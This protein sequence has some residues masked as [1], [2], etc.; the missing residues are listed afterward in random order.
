MSKDK[1]LVEVKGLKTY[2]HVNGGMFAPK[3]IV[4]AVD[5]VSFKV[6]PGETVG[7]VGESGSGKTTVGRTM[8]RL[9]PAEAGEV[10]FDGK[11]VMKMDRKEL[12]SLRKRM[13]M[14]FQDPA[15]S[16]NPRMTVSTIVSEPLKLH[17]NMTRKERM[18]RV[19][20]LLE[21]SGLSR[22]YVNRYPHEF[23]GGQRQRIGIARALATNPDFIVCDE[24]V[25]AL[26][27]SIQAQILNL[28]KDLQAELGLSYLFVAHNLAVVEHFV[29]RLCV[30]YHGKIVESADR[31]TL[32]ANPQNDYT[33]M[34]L[35]A[36]PSA[37]PRNRKLNQRIKELKK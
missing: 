13:Q 2:F 37:D 19:G 10:F 31:D 5:D 24:P 22:A 11:D 27:V 12:R 33:K 15:S 36:V 30:M 14:I 3:R 20:E 34:L 1:P 8:L 26:D 25:S 7:L 18:R 21:M 23:S 16:L 28:L 35:S 4:K 32:Y 9:I 6:Y 17:F 29:D